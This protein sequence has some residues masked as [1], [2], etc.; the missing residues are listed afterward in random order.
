MEKY[1]EMQTM[2]FDAGNPSR[3]HPGASIF[4]NVNFCGAWKASSALRVLPH[5]EI[6]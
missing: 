3:R 5:S 1:M 6:V 4:R 2:G